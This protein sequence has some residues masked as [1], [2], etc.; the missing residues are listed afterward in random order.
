MCD[1]PKVTTNVS[2]PE[3]GAPTRACRPTN[4]RPLRDPRFETDYNDMHT[5][6]L[7]RH[8]ILILPSQLYRDDGCKYCGNCRDERCRVCNPGK[9]NDAYQPM[10]CPNHNG[11]C[12]YN[13]P[14][15]KSSTHDYPFSKV[16]LAIPY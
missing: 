6:M 2:Y 10:R 16:T 13:V 4:V 1:I 15:L 7:N 12:M 5:D 11:T 14:E 8:H 3:C 9:Y